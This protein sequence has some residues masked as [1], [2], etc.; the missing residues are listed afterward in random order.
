VGTTGQEFP[1]HESKRSREDGAMVSQQRPL[2]E[3]LAEMLDVRCHRRKRRPLAA[4]SALPTIA[5]RI[6][7]M[8]YDTEAQHA[9]AG[10]RPAHVLA[11]AL[12]LRVILVY[13]AQFEDHGPFEERLSR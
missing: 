4:I 12:A 2:I 11:D 9:S 8:L 3:I 10:E 1:P 7:G 13:T 5:S 6:N